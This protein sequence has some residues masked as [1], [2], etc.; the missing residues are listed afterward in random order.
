ME[1][2]PARKTRP[3]YVTLALVAIIMFSLFGFLFFREMG[4][5]KQPDRCQYAA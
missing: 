5:A 1:T 4:K 2:K 3:F